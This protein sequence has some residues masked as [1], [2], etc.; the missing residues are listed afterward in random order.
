MAD[1]LLT[2]LVTYGRGYALK[3]DDITGAL[4]LSLASDSPAATEMRAI[5]LK[6]EEV[7][8]ERDLGLTILEKAPALAK[9]DSKRVSEVLAARLADTAASEILQALPDTHDDLVVAL[10]RDIEDAAEEDEERVLS[11]ADLREFAEAAL[12]VKRHSLALAA[13]DRLLAFDSQEG[14]TE[15][16]TIIGQFAPITDPTRVRSVLGTASVAPS[17]ST[18]PQWLEPVAPAAVEALDDSDA[19]V[20]A[21]IKTLWERRFKPAGA[22]AAPALPDEFLS[23]GTALARLRLGRSPRIQLGRQLLE[24]LPP[25]PVTSASDTDTRTEQHDALLELVSCGLSPPDFAARLVLRD[26]AQTLAAAIAPTTPNPVAAWV[27]VA[28][29]KV[30]GSASADDIEAFVEALEGSP[31]TA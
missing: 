22:Q 11:P 5:V 24:A 3:P 12:D 9:A 23:A 7:L 15:A 16:E 30:L 21:F 8:S 29:A 20:E 13:F 19:L 28:C 2:A 4:A 25:S 26:L 17:P 14:R 27:H 18:W 31:C 6:R 10:V 1:E